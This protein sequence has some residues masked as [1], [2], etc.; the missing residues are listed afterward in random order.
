VH[1]IR[2][3]SFNWEDVMMSQSLLERLE[4]R[5][6]LSASIVSRELVA[7]GTDDRDSIEL[8][9]VGID[10]VRVTVWTGAT[11][12]PTSQQTFDMD[13]FD[14][15]RVE[16]LGNNDQL[17]VAQNGFI[18]N[19]TMNGGAGNDRLIGGAAGETFNGGEGA[20]NMS[21]N[22]GDDTFTGENGY[23]VD[24]T[25][26]GGAGKDSFSLSTRSVN[27]TVNGDTGNDNFNYSNL[28]EDAQPMTLQI[29]GGADNDTL[30]IF[31][32]GVPLH[33]D[34]GA[35]IDL[36]A[37]P[38]FDQLDLNDYPTVEDTTA[39]SGEVI[40]NDLDNH[41]SFSEGHGVA[42]GGKGNDILD[43]DSNHSQGVEFFGE[44][45]NDTL[46]GSWIS[47]DTLDGG[48][49][50]D[51]L[52]G[53]GAGPESARLLG[54][55]DTLTGGDGIDTLDGDGQSVYNSGEIFPGTLTAI[56]FEDAIN[57][58]GT[59]GRDSIEV[60][61]LNTGQIRITIWTNSSTPAL[62]QTFSAMPVILAGFNA[63]DK[64]FVANAA[65]LGLPDTGDFDVNFLGG[66]GN[67]YLYGSGDKDF[68]NG[69]PGS[70]IY[71][72]NNGDDLFFAVDTT[73]DTIDG[74]SGN[75]TANAD[76]NDSIVNVET[77]N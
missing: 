37:A 13:D 58:R 10:D 25:A 77:V 7:L 41:I 29:F 63:D 5:R 4:S 44:E 53:N 72:G 55:G 40:G 28:D 67:D 60:R 49:G 45:G 27:T 17:F 46:L 73:P 18:P 2:A 38:S 14:S 16:G 71:K 23:L 32:E 24:D 42:H 61:R 1:L 54:F 3:D 66:A 68:F 57:V 52:R 6:L 22:G 8:R 19:L 39:E 21:G 64:L 20:D 69:G 15:V 75:D 70:D 30:G 59:M 33:F 76:N 35:G 50:N 11:S 51:I 48:P 34:G 65:D 47:A 12:T 74:G 56:V 9:R 26:S 43:G 62:Q 31:P 36:I